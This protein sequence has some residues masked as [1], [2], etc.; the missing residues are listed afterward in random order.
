MTHEYLE[1]QQRVMGSCMGWHPERE[2]QLCYLQEAFSLSLGITN[3]QFLQVFQCTDLWARSQT[4]GIFYFSTNTKLF[5]EPE[6]FIV[7]LNTVT[8]DLK[9]PMLQKACE[10]DKCRPMKIRMYIKKALW[11]TQQPSHHKASDRP[12]TVWAASTWSYKQQQFACPTSLRQ[13]YKLEGS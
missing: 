5:Q 9:S 8:H 4:R 6:F 13:K 7:C 2:K 11:L 10:Q 1:R 3:K 12:E